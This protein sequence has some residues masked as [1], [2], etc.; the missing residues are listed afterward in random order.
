[1]SVQ[2]SF[3]PLSDTER[4]AYLQAMDVPV[5]VARSEPEIELHLASHTKT[6]SESSF[7]D[8]AINE[9]KNSLQS[10]TDSTLL[11]DCEVEPSYSSHNSKIDVPRIN[12]ATTDNTNVHQQSTFKDSVSIASAAAT[13]AKTHYLKRINWQAGDKD[14]DSVLIIC[15]HQVDQPANSFAKANMPSRIMQDFVLALIDNAA[16]SYA[17]QTGTVQPDSPQTLRIELSNLSQAGLGSD[18]ETLESVLT[19]LKPKAVLLLG[20][21]T[22]KELI[23]ANL[24]VVQLRGKMQE[25]P[26]VNTPCLVSY[27]PFDLIKNPALKKLAMEDLYLFNQLISA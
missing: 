17:A 25:L 12:K 4:L 18:C 14:G 27:H 10:S 24:D 8:G 11:N 26:R 20:D 2:T 15:R 7:E 6:Y 1:M 9:A 13:A 19:E 22:V 3:Q 5:W 21:E 16:Q 23:N